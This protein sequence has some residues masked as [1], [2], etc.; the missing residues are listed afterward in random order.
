MA[1]FIATD[2]NDNRTGTLDDDTII[3]LLGNDR[4]SALSGN[5]LIFGDRLVAPPNLDGRTDRDSLFGDQGN[6]TLF[7][8]AGADMVH[9][10]DDDDLLYGDY[11]TASPLA[12]NDAL[13][14]E[15][16]ND[17][18]YGG[19]GDDSANGGLGDDTIYGGEGDDTAN[20]GLGDDSIH[21]EDG[22]DLLLGS[23][24]NDLIFGD[25]GD[26]T[27]NGGGGDDTIHGGGGRNEIVDM[28]GN[29]RVRFAQSVETGDGMD[30]IR[31]ARM[32][33]SGGGDDDIYNRNGADMDGGVIAAGAGD[34]KIKVYSTG[35][36]LL[37]QNGDDTIQSS[38]SADST[39]VGGRGA[40][41]ISGAGVLR[42]NNGDDILSAPERALT[43]QLFGGWGD[44]TLTAF[45]L[46]D[47]TLS[48]GEGVD[49]FRLTGGGQSDPENVATILDFEPGSER[50]G[51]GVQISYGI[52]ISDTLGLDD[53]TLIQSGTDVL[54]AD[55]DRYYARLSDQIATD[56]DT[57][58]FFVFYY[59]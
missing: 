39:L 10:G 11:A 51:I 22:N 28:A 8:G 58:D 55:A 48:G 4:V 45:S 12:G 16:G 27:I 26:D 5:D 29:N 13:F 18:I 43:S 32:I 35:N 6:D 7:G 14:G 37:G 1:L 23:H 33:S 52:E 54:V 36:R 19:A 56:L 59:F 24:G 49:E 21:G 47:H 41:E 40:D 57:S 38:S 17:V 30:I 46:T 25:K 44:D 53:I 20:G 2:G 3:G 31:H 42:G 9:G 15:D 50:I 34:D